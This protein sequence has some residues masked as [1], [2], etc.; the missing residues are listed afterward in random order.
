MDVQQNNNLTPREDRLRLSLPPGTRVKVR[1]EEWLVRSC[2]HDINLDSFII[3]AEG[4]KGIVDGLEMTFLD[5]LDKVEVVDP[6]NVKIVP[7]FSPKFQKSKLFVDIHFRNTIPVGPDISIGDKAAINSEPWQH[8]GAFQALNDKVHLRPRILL[9][10]AVGLGKTVQVGILLSEL[11]KRGKGNRVLVVCLKSMAEQFQKEIWSRFSVPLKFIDSQELR[12]IEGEIPSSRN[13][14]NVHNKIIMSMDT[15]KQQG[16]MARLEGTYWDAIII[17]EC[18]NVAKRKTASGRAKLARKLSAI[19][20][21]L[22]LTSATP[23]DGSHESYG[24]LLELLDPTIVVDP[25][26][27]GPDQLVKYALRRFHGDVISQDPALQPDDQPIDCDY[28]EVEESTLLSLRGKKFKLLRSKSD[29]GDSLFSGTLAKSLFSSP[30]AFKSVAEN[31]LKKLEGKLGD[32]TEDQEFLNESLK[33]LKSHNIKKTNKYKE[34]VSFLEEGKKGEKHQRTV[35]FTEYR[36]TLQALGEVLKKDLGLKISKKDTE[37]DDKAEVVVLHA[38]VPEA[39][40]KEIIDSFGTKDS[41]IQV[42]LATDVASEGL[43]LHYNCNRLVHYD[44]PWSLIRIEQRNGRINRYGQEKKP[45]I[46]YLISKSDNDDLAKFQEGHVSNR[47]VEKYREVKKQLGDTGRQ[48][49]LFDPLA[50]SDSVQKN[51]GEA[52]STND[53]DDF[54]AEMMG[55]PTVCDDTFGSFQGTTANDVR[56]KRINTLYDD[57]DFFKSALSEL[58]VKTKEEKEKALIEIPIKDNFDFFNKNIKKVMKPLAKELKL[59][60]D[61][62]LRL[63]KNVD[64]VISSIKDAMKEK[65][66][67]PEVQYLWEVHPLFHHLSKRLEGTFANDEVLL[68]NLSPNKDI[69]TLN[70]Y[71]LWLG[72]MSNKRGDNVLNEVVLINKNG[73]E[74]KLTD[75]LDGLHDLSL[76]NAPS[77][78]F[79]FTKGYEKEVEKELKETFKFYTDKLTKEITK[80]YNERQTELQKF[81]KS[82]GEWK[83]LK[84]NY[85]HQR[86]EKGSK[87]RFKEENELVESIYKNYSKLIQH[88]FDIDVNKPYLKPLLVVL[89]DKELS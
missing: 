7:D 12:K 83:E 60:K 51:F 55:E 26:Q 8:V 44:V 46:R 49:G 28:L 31:R 80:E 74:F 25:K 52:L 71:F 72:A 68:C 29:R 21:S 15:L 4:A 66:L 59:T 86:F 50:E 62:T 42:L 47:L 9:A 75:G 22:I 2:E 17:D 67:W 36:K 23:H 6:L 37:F 88:Y 43:N 11:I 78:E 53:E 76:N 64:V 81:R 16:M 33:A 38:G 35:V 3:K 1:G 84:L 19:C 34:L 54:L 73:N 69:K 41:K 45:I 5:A 27:C 40:Q 24:S 82:L 56:Y 87:R 79:K 57:Y 32:Y 70:K 18:H 20:E 65:G 89:S 58:K 77:T 63:S 48:M 13:P 30:E 10:D 39:T 14:L 85:N 61:S